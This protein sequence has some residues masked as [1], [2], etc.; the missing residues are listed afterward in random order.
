MPE[1]Y[2]RLMRISII[3]TDNVKK[4]DDHKEGDKKMNETKNVK[5]K[6][7]I[8]EDEESATM[9]LSII[10]HERAAEFLY[11]TTGTEAVELCKK[12]PDIDVVLMDIKMP[13]MDGYVATQRIRKFNKDVVIIAQTA[14]AITG[15]REKS[16][17][18]G[19]NGYISKPIDEEELLELIDQLV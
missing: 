9:F 14:Y 13:E 5:L 3:Q 11:A 1:Y 19:C 18:A 2:I 15:D 4:T 12:N 16:L 7:L 6:I 10:L 8:A 17:D